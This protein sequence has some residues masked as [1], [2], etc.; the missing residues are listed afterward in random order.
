MDAPQTALALTPLN[1]TSLEEGTLSTIRLLTTTTPTSVVLLT[2][3]LILR[4]PFK[5]DAQPTTE[6]TP[7]TNVAPATT[8]LTDVSF[9]SSKTK[10]EILN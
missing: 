7:A 4:Q 6:T 1:A 3:A 10:F 5:E 9:V 8:G 2:T